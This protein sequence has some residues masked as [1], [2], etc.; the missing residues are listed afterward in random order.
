MK[1]AEFKV[2]NKRNNSSAHKY[3]PRKIMSI[4]NKPSDNV[5][6]RGKD[7]ITKLHIQGNEA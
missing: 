3:G 2:F 6:S 4:M 5:P 1:S 7:E